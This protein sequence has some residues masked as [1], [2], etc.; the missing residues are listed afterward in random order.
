M[1]ENSEFLVFMESEDLPEGLVKVV[2]REK[3]CSVSCVHAFYAWILF[4][5]RFET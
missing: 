3:L 2:T 5:F 4:T 1:I